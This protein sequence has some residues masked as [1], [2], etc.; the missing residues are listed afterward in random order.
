MLVQISDG[1]AISSSF[2]FDPIFYVIKM[3]PG[4]SQKSFSD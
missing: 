3:Y 4:E 2:Y 1:K